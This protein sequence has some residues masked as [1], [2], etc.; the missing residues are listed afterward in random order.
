MKKSIKVI[1][2][3]TMIFS[4]FASIA[5]ADSTTGGSAS[6]QATSAKTSKDF[7]DLKDLDAATR[8]KFDAMISAGIFDGTTD[9][10]FGL[11]EEMNRAQFAKVAALVMGLELNKDLKTSS[12]SDVKADDAA[13]GY[14]LPYIEALKAANVT[15]G[16]GEGTYNPAGKVTKEQLATFLVRVLGK[17]AEAKGK[18]GTDTTVSGWAQGYVALALELKLFPKAEGAF[19]GQSN[20]TRDLLLTGAYEAKAQY[21][22]PGKLTVT[23]AKATGVQKA[24]VSF[25]KPVDTTKATLT[26]KK[27]SSE[28]KTT[29][30]WSDDKKTATLT[31]ADEKLRAGEYTVS[32]DGLDINSVDKTSATFKAEDEVLKSVDFVTAGDTIAYSKST[33]VK[34]KALNQYGE[35][36]SFSAGS[37]TVY[38]AAAKLIKITK[39]DDGLLAITLDT[40]S[41]GGTQGVSMV[42]VSVINNDQHVT[43]SKSFKLGTKPILTKLE[44][45]EA[46]YSNS[47]NAITGKGDSAT[48]DLNLF[49]QYGG[50]IAYDSTEFHKEDVSVVW[51]EYVGNNQ[52]N[53]NVVT[54]E[55]EDN[56]NNIP[57]LKISLNENVD[58]SADYTFTVLD[59]A[60]TATGKV[61]IRSVAVATKVEIGDFNDVIAAGDKDVYIPVIAYDASG[62]QLNIEDLTSDTN[63]ERIQV[64]VTGANNGGKAEISDSGAHRGTIHLKNITDVSKGSV[65]VTLVVATPNATSTA[66]KT[67]IVSDA[68]V[69]DRIKEVSKPSKEYI[70]GSYGAFQYQVLDQYG[71]VMNYNIPTSGVNGNAATG[72]NPSTSVTYDVYLELKDAAPGAFTVTRN[73]GS[74]KAFALA[75]GAK[76]N[77]SFSNEDES[78]GDSF[79]QFNKGLR[80]YAGDATH[81]DQEA[82]VKVSIRKKEVGA[83]TPTVISYVEEKI[84]VA[85]TADSSTGEDWTYTMKDLGTLYDLID[86]DTLL[87]SPT[88]ISTDSAN[89]YKLAAK[90]RVN[91]TV[92]N[93]SGD[94]VA[95]PNNFVQ[96]VTS[97]NTSAVKVAF[98]PN[99]KRWYVVGNKVGTSTITATYVDNKGKTK[100]ATQVVK[101]TDDAPT[102]ASMTADEKATVAVNK[103]GA[104]TLAAV[105]DYVSTDAATTN[106]DGYGT[107]YSMGLTNLSFTDSNGIALDSKDVLDMN[108]MY[109]LTFSIQHV[110]GNGNGVPTIDQAT[111]NVT[112]PQNFAGTFDIVVTA[113]SGKTTTTEVTVK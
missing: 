22:A 33:V 100:T 93:A 99:N 85:P 86:S 95:I 20:A 113:P 71:K 52:S 77:K 51:N 92:K 6:T 56:G 8:V 74:E 58:K 10:T 44:L 27:G 45:G 36:A 61:S 57:R 91:F 63:R 39:Q 110:N 82:T 107:Q 101:V 73:D 40:E 84:K 30:K 54:T 41:G 1:T 19:G 60:A 83:A 75:D 49:D 15:D 47:S 53:Q 3:A 2:S 103:A 59:Q 29:A 46:K 25:N 35:N 111:S 79:K 34:A 66:T 24:E 65:S 14:A 108:F 106:T 102:I 5:M 90:K 23:G 13:N 12:F 32:V 94:L 21:V 104:T 88:P 81:V 11:K 7:T 97:S 42:T 62:K 64:N 4:M 70:A 37:Y 96:N 109:G 48:F 38:P 55:I 80:I 9:T 28:I 112:I 105:H 98:N 31:L 89:L 17:D 43:A 69:P 16:Y 87:N 50:N 76:I 72:G 68:R 78:N 67:F 18:T 26:L